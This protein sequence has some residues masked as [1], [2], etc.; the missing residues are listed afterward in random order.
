[1]NKAFFDLGC[2]CKKSS[3]VWRFR[4]LIPKAFGKMRPIPSSERYFK[5]KSKE[6]AKAID[7]VSNAKVLVERIN[8]KAG[9][10]KNGEKA[11]RRPPSGGDIIADVENPKA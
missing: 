5:K 3:A 6:N 10:G 2:P 9:T 1:V 8:G 4:S 11:R 7:Q